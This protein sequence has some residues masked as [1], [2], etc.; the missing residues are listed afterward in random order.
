MIERHITEAAQRLNV[1]TTTVSSILISLMGYMTNDRTGGINGFVDSFRRAGIG[2]VVTSWFGGREGKH[3]TPSHI[4][5]AL[6][7]SGVQ[8]IADASGVTRIIASSAIAL[9]LPRLI[10][11]LTPNGTLPTNES[12]RQTIAKVLNTPAPV[13]Q[14][15]A[16]PRST[17]RWLPWAAAAALALAAFFLM[18]DRTP[19]APRIATDSTRIVRETATGSLPSIATSRGP[20]VANDLLGV[21]WELAGVSTP[22]GERT[23]DTP[24]RYTVRFD[25]GGRLAVRADCNRGTGT[26]TVS[27]DQRLMVNPLALTRAMCPPGSMSDRF[28][29]QVS[30]VTRYEVRGEDL[31]LTLAP[32][33]G[34]LRF[35]RAPN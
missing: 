24:D 28:A 26:Y 31:Y 2:E 5:A 33:S 14:R 7:T 20:G 12:A 15:L 23:I 6:S 22:I 21:T 27:S 4:E 35:R 1:P 17:S 19:A 16:E 8:R 13:P 3:V 25:S 9:L 34:T 11:L 18:R 29:A 10:A 32:D 30:R